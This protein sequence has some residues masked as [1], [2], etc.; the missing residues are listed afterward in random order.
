MSKIIKLKKGFDINLAGKAQKKIA[1]TPPSE[2]F[3]IKPT[4]FVGMKR[5]KLLV[6]EG[7]NVKAGSPVL[8]DKMQENVMICSPVSGEVVEVKRGAK[9]KLLEI[10]ILADKEIEYEQFNTYN[11]SDIKGL[12]R[13]D[14]VA[15]MTKGGVWANIIQRP[16]GVIANEEDSPKSIFISAFDTHPLAADPAFT[17]KGEEE[18]FRTGIEILKK[19]TEGPIHLNHDLNGEVSSVFANIEGI[20]HN[21]VSGP[22]P[23]GNVGVQIHHI[24]P[25]G[26]GD[27]VWTVTPFG[28]AQIG[29]LFSKGVYD[30]SR[31]VA[32]AG[33]ELKDPQYIKTYTGACVNKLVDG[34]L[35]QDHVR[36]ISGNVLTGEK[37]E[38]D[39]Y[40]GFYDNLLSVLPEG[41]HAEFLGWIK[42]KKDVLS[43]HRAW[44]LFSFLNGKDKEYVLDTNT[45]GEPR[46]F[47]ETGVFE[48]VTPMDIY[49]VYLIKAI[50]AED[51]DNMEALGIYE[52]VEEDLALCEYVD[53][54]KHDVQQIVREGIELMQNG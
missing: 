41:D 1:N 50:M 32:V 2:T 44:G 3:A 18:A 26:K 48:K 35:K 20:Q 15:Q 22:H 40:L 43:F 34:N 19:F 47:V 36:F 29:K 54:S 39:G 49:P 53:V 33:S 12:S 8:Y 16:Y 38:K 42:P 13:E 11:V 25:I 6:A 28:V 37:V 9:R 14:A 21:K 30:A 24:D 17:L 45:N 23:A 46:A 51:Y 52:V 27:L 4:D 10:K 7:D 5:P 31:V